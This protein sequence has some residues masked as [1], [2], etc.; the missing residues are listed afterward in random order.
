M[1][2]PVLAARGLSKSYGNV[3]AVAGVDLEVQA[4]Q[5]IGLV[6]NNGAGKTT[7]MKLLC[8]ILEPGAG[9]ALLGGRPT[10]EPVV[11]QGLGFLPEDSPLYDDQTPL[12]YLAFFGGL[13]GM[14]KAAVRE[15][16]ESLL[17][18]LRL[19]REHWTKPIGELSKGS[20]RK[21]ALARAFLHD[22]AVL[23]L[24]EPASGL[25]PA[26]RRELDLFLSAQR[27]AGKAILLSAHNLKQV[28]ELCDAILLMHGGRIVAHGSL[29]ELRQRWGTARYRLHATVPFTGSAPAGTVHLGSLD[30]LREAESAM[31]EVRNAGGQVI[32]LESV[33]PPLEEILRLASESPGQVTR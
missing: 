7:L 20:A 19:G 12:Q 13:Y 25:D 8:G 6:G 33:P 26:T 10:S 21:V 22:P 31:E 30:G 5:I 9:A 3:Q 11:R 23:L 17:D 28:E 29:A 1:P 14:R 2:G 16:S 15:R 32:E 24:D 27:E 4:K 18:A